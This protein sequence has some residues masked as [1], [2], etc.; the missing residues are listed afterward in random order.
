MSTQLLKCMR[1]AVVG[2]LIFLS[3]QPFAAQDRSSA[4]GNTYASLAKLPDWSGAWVI[5]WAAFAAE[6]KRLQNPN[7]PG[8]PLLTP[9]YGRLRDAY[10]AN[11][12]Q[13]QSNGNGRVVDCG[14]LPGMP[15][16]MRWAFAIEFLFTPGRVTILLEQ[17]STIRRIYTD[18]RT[19]TIDPDPS[20]LGESIGHWEGE[21]LV[22]HTTALSAKTP[23]R[24]GLP[25]S[26]NA[27]ITER[28]HRTDAN[29]LQIDTAVEDPV[30]LTAPWRYS[31][32]YE[33]TDPVFLETECEVNRDGND[34]EPDLTPPPN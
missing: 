12:A 21:T 13:Q 10:L 17:A 2:S 31:R 25:T 6:N 16:I 8:A 26:G 15:N 32:I 27:Q 18:G 3:A 1:R 20:Y 28:I 33:R 29:H 24:P 9:E 19:H 4:P 23:L 11:L 5:P 34:Q 22:V 14:G 7:D 30:A